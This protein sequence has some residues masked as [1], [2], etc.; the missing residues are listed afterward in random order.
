M[1]RFLILLTCVAFGAYAEYEAARSVSSMRVDEHKKM[2]SKNLNEDDVRFMR[3]AIEL[4]HVALEENSGHPFGSVV[5]RDGE[6]VGEGWNRTK[7]LNDP[8]A[9]AETEAIR[10][11]CRN[12]KTTM[13]KG[14][15]IY[16]SAEP[17][18]MCLSLIYLT[19]VEKVYYCIPG[20]KVD[21]IDPSLSVTHIY[22]SLGKA[23]PERPLPE[24]AIMPEEADNII[25]RYKAHR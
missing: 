1:I 12:L 17:C 9:H 5:V 8:S 3:R 4:S 14:C 11:A 16:A 23:I 20:S 7:V 18:P 22:E 2:Q 24:V 10:E 25:E 15:V 13:L 6:I 19:G 21:S